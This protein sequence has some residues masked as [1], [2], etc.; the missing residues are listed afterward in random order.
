M[1]AAETGTF[2]SLAASARKAAVSSVGT[3]RQTGSDNPPCGG[4]RSGM[5]RVPLQVVVVRISSNVK[6]IRMLLPGQFGQLSEVDLLEVLLLDA[7]GFLP[8]VAKD[9]PARGRVDF[10]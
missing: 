4:T 6:H 7:V 10:M 2:V 9:V 5:M 3:V 1:S 8:D